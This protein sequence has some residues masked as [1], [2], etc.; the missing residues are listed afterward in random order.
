M[1]DTRPQKHVVLEALKSLLIVLL[2]LSA[3]Y[4][5][6]SSQLYGDV[7]SDWIRSI[8][9][10][11]TQLLGPADNSPAETTQSI[12]PVRI[13][14]TNESGRYGAQYDTTTVDAV[15]DQLA[16]LL[17][18]ALSSGCAPTEISADEWVQSLTASPSIYFDLLGSVPLSALS[19]W[20]SGNSSNPLLFGTVRRLSLSADA[21]GNVLL[22]YVNEEDSLY[23]AC[24]T[25]IVSRDQLFSAVSSYTANEALFAFEQSGYAAL[26]PYT[27]LLPDTPS[28]VVYSAS[29]PLT[30]ANLSTLLTAL[31][32]R[33]QAN[34]IYQSS[35]GQV[36]R[37][38]N[39]TLRIANNG[40]AT[41]YTSEPDSPLFSLSPGSSDAD[42]IDLARSL[43]DST[44]GLWCGDARLYLSSAQLLANGTYQVDFNYC[45]NGAAV[46]TVAE[47]GYAARFIFSDNQ[48]TDF[49]L[50]FR[51]YTATNTTTFVLPEL[52]AVAALS[53][54]NADGSE[55]LLC[56]QDTGGDTVRA[57]WIAQ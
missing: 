50:C 42:K 16:V 8:K 52:Q 6:G 26:Y 13:A 5:A 11:S 39:D 21:D 57:G 24:I 9:T 17:N 53:A 20:L 3:I 31:S 4:L 28:P 15:Y 40:V 14:V 35:E 27:L 49:T 47:E 30:S 18:E 34:S 37:S 33:V 22:S 12:Y 25:E 38:G 41:Y 48:L 44:V 2:S 1:N 43:T 51:C 46:C 32:F 19:G 56:Y 55:L 29:S 23:Y 45:L 10:S 54:L 36:V 7:L